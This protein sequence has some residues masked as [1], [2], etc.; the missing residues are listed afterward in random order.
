MS[1]I[2]PLIYEHSD[3]KKYTQCLS[4]KNIRD[5]QPAH[6][7]NNIVGSNSSSHRNHAQRL[8]PPAEMVFANLA[9]PL[10]KKI[11]PICQG[12]SDTSLVAF[13]GRAFAHPEVLAAAVGRAATPQPKLRGIQSIPPPIIPPRI[14]AVAVEF[15]I[16][17]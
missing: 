1:I 12:R 7:L 13:L 3:S 4:V 16:F 15:Q 17:P 9:V 14:V 10:V 2:T 11:M 6:S 8:P 5:S